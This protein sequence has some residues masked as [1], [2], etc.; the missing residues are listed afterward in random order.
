MAHLHTF[1]CRRIKPS[2]IMNWSGSLG[3][4]IG[5]W[6]LQCTIQAWC[7]GFQ[8]FQSC[9]RFL[10]TH[11][12]YVPGSKLP[13]F[14]YN[15]GQTHQPNSRGLYTHY[16]DSYS[17]VGWPSPILRFLTMAHMKIASLLEQPVSCGS[18]LWGCISPLASDCAPRPEAWK[19]SLRAKG[20]GGKH[21]WE[22]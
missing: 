2:F 17:K 1:A 12:A 20:R 7:R 6:T 22:R 16:K 18:P 3:D 13:L 8:S 11:V 9:L 5:W 10:E 21:G 4:K 14:P 19:L 15:R